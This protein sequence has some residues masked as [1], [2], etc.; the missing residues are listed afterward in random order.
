M[1]IPGAVV[2]ALHKRAA[3]NERAKERGLRWGEMVS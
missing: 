3:P 1:E 2:P